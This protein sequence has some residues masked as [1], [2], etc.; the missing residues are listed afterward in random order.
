MR[1]Y[2]TWEGLHEDDEIQHLIMYTE[3]GDPSTYEE[4]KD[5]EKWKNAMESE[6]Q[7]IERNTW[8]LTCLPAGSKGIGVKWLY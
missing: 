2:E 8:N 3:S 7:A 6:I 1:D 4:A 5:C